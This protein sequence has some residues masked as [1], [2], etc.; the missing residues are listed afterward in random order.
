MLLFLDTLLQMMVDGSLEITVY[1]KPTHIDLYLDFR[2]HH[3]SMARGVFQV[4]IRKGL[5]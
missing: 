4:P 5:G 2:S 1:K 3:P